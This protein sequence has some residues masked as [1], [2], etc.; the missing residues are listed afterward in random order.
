MWGR[1]KIRWCNPDNSKLFLKK[2]KGIKKKERDLKKTLMEQQDLSSGF[3]FYPIEHLLAENMSLYSCHPNKQTNTTVI[4]YLE[5]EREREGVC[6]CVC[7][8]L[9]LLSI[10]GST[11]L[12]SGCGRGFLFFFPTDCP[13]VRASL[14]APRLVLFSIR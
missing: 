5:R 13:G 12:K 1:E 10:L 3:L 14:R 6:E 7:W 8:V 2:I 9:L 4:F 11:A